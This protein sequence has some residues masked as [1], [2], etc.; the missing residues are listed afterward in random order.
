MLGFTWRARAR[1]HMDLVTVAM[2][3]PTKLLFPP[4]PWKNPLATKVARHLGRSASYPEPWVMAETSPHGSV[5]RG[6]LWD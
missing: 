3:S 2:V 6:L 1:L 4:I 5:L